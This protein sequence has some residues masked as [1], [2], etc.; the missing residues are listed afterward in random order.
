MSISSYQHIEPSP[1]CTNEMTLETLMT[2]RKFLERSLRT[3]H[4]NAEEMDKL[5]ACPIDPTKFRKLK[6]YHER[7]LHQTN[8]FIEEYER[9]NRKRSKSVITKYIKWF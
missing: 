3:Y 9:E 6:A 5:Q 8:Q 4:A 1:F 2:R 7:R